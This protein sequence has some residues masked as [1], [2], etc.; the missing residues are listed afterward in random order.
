MGVKFVNMT[1]DEFL[2]KK[3]LYKYM[4]LEFA[5][6][7]IK[8]KYLWL[9]NPTI[10]KD[11]FEKRFIDAKYL[12]GSSEKTYPIKGQLFCMCMTQTTTSEAHWNIYS[13]GQIGISFKIR[14]KQLLNVLS[15]HIDDYDI[16]IGKVN[17]LRSQDIK[18][19]LSEIETIKDIKPF[20]INN[21]KLQIQ[22]LLLKRIAFKYEDE[23]RILAVK[24]YKTKEN[25]IKLSYSIEPNK[26]IDTIT[27]DPN[28]GLNTEH[29]L[30]KLFTHEYNFEKVYKSQLYS[31]PNDIKIKL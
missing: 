1:E 15:N 23:I 4:P 8:D 19:S 26:L 29:T 30:K 20:N 22:L 14:R 21:R 17:Y 25:G 31:M 3:I 10:W 6:G 18:K 27:I 2:S 24:K 7:M 11:P 12:K 13:N 28:V 16:Y 9:C 5:L